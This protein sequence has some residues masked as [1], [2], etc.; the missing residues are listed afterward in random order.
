M[1]R[2]FACRRLP[3]YPIRCPFKRLQR[4][5]KDLPS[6]DGFSSHVLGA[7]TYVLVDANYQL[8]DY[9]AYRKGARLYRFRSHGKNDKKRFNGHYFVL[10]EHYEHDVFV[11]KYYPK[12]LKLAGIRK[13]QI[14]AGTHDVQRIVA[15]VADIAFSALA[16][17]PVASFAFIGMPSV[18]H[19]HDGWVVETDVPSQR[20]RIYAWYVKRMPHADLF[21]HRSWGAANAYLLLNNQQPDHKILENRIMDM[22]IASYDTILDP[23]ATDVDTGGTAT[24]G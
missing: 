17:C 13:Y 3:P 4:C 1:L 20:F 6:Q 7:Y 15:T 5:A 22:F 19:E 11:V 21:T 2:L 24:V 16:D 14:I 23:R 18:F 10:V 9:C 8:E 12:S